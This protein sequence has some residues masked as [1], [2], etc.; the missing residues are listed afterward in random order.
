MCLCRLTV[1]ARLVQTIPQNFLSAA[2]TLTVIRLALAPAILWTIIEQSYFASL[3]IFAIAVFT[4]VLDGRLARRQGTESNLGGLFDHATDCIFVVCA[5]FALSRH[6]IVPL[7]LSGM[8]A[9]AFIQYVLDSG[10]L[11]RKGLVPSKLGRWNG[12]A[13][14]VVVAIPL[15]QNSFDFRLISDHQV[16]V[17]GWA[18]CVM[19]LASMF[20]RASLFFR[21][22][23]ARQD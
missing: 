17:G 23:R 2:N 7:A 15:V 13:Y 20:D 6:E 21:K 4:D 1:T 10:A 12:I 5:L 22:S 19:T 14:F 9:A 18:M 11:K 3:C 16:L 8:V